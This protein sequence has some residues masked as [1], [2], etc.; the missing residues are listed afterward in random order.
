VNGKGY[1]RYQFTN[2]SED[3][4]TIFCRACDLCGVEWRRMKRNA[5]SVARKPS[6]AKLDE[7]I[8]PKA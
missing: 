1:P 8:G 3:I 7:F 5:I 4:R 6:V 2:E